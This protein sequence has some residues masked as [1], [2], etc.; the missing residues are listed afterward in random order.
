MSFYLSFLAVWVLWDSC[1]Y[2]LMSF[3]SC[4]KVLVISSANVTSAAFISL[5]PVGLPFY[6]LHLFYMCLY[7]SSV[8]FIFLL[9]QAFFQIDSSDSSSSSPFLSA[10]LSNL[11]LM[12]NKTKQKTT[13]K[14][15]FHWEFNFSCC[16]YSV[17]KF[18]VSS[19]SSLQYHFL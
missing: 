19:F 6:L 13:T 8:F 16:I 9:I 5:F 12:P 10:S 3:I 7:L 2:K 11:S 14:N 4:R 17:L 1:F 15:P 18:S